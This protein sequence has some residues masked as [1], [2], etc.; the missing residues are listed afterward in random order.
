MV[1]FCLKLLYTL[2]RFV[3]KMC[4]KSHRCT[5]PL[6]A[7]SQG[8]QVSLFR[9]HTPLGVCHQAWSIAQDSSCYPGL[10]SF[11]GKN[12]TF[13]VTSRNCEREFVTKGMLKCVWF[14]FVFINPQESQKKVTLSCLW[15]AES[16]Q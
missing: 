4:G 16:P 13:E 6:L 15:T 10:E 14:S 5:G 8:P 12:H 2:E 7:R 9:V 3:W 1:S 11:T